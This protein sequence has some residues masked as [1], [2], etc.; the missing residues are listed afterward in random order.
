MTGSY[1]KAP[2]WEKQLF[3][4]KICGN[5]RQKVGLRSIFPGIFRPAPEDGGEKFRETLDIPPG[6][7]YRISTV[8]KH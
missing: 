7:W 1:Y 3:S 8:R 6:I 4:W 5:N 2:Q